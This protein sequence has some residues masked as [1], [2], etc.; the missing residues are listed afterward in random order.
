MRHFLLELPLTSKTENQIENPFA[1]YPQRRIAMRVS[2]DGTLY[3]G[4]QIQPQFPLQTI[5]G[6][7]QSVLA[8]VL[9]V[10]TPLDG[11][12]RTDAGV[13]AHD[14]L[15]AF[16]THHPIRLQGLKMS[17]NRRLPS[18]IVVQTVQEVGLDFQPRFANQGKIYVYYIWNHPTDHPIHARFATHIRKTLDLVAMSEAM[19]LL[20]G[21]HDFKSFA[22]QDG[23][24]K[25]SVRTLW[26]VSIHKES[27]SLIAIRFGGNGFMKQ[28]VRN[29]VGTLIEVGRG[30]WHAQKVVA[31][32]AACDRSA[33]GPTA[34]AKGLALEQMF[35][36]LDD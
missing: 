26:H 31:I 34:A 19:E 11:A 24:H 27:P 12:S 22:A 5:Q 25:T 8:E 32:L 1:H 4:W 35:W 36:E 2:Y 23:Q 29:L 15:C 10:A 9:Q 18:D 20:K 3:H 16:T 21:T 14:Q 7:L 17:L 33:A 13:H 30:R 6:R 28:M